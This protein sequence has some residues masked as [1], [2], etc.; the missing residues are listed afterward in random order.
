MTFR[1][2]DPKAEKSTHDLIKPR[3]VEIIVIN[4]GTRK[5]ETVKLE[6]VPQNP[7]IDLTLRHF[8]PEHSYFEL[9]IPPFMEFSEDKTYAF[10]LSKGNA[11][12]LLD[13]K[14]NLITVQGKT[15]DTM[16]SSDFQLFIFTDELCGTLLSTIR[17]EVKALPIIYRQMKAG[18]QNTIALTFPVDLANQVQVYSSDPRSLYLPQTNPDNL[19]TV[20]PG[21]INYI[22]VH[23]KTYDP[24]EKK[25]IVNAISKCPFEFLFCFNLFFFADNVSGELVYSWLIRM[26]SLHPKPNETKSVEAL[27][28]RYTTAKIMFC[29]PSKRELLYEFGTSHPKVY[30]PVDECM[31]F[32][33][34]HA[35]SIELEIYPQTQVCTFKTYLFINDVEHTV[36]HCIELQIRFLP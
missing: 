19:Q 22:E 3:V 25:V 5:D 26:Q 10:R 6:L 28:N 17:V 29:N 23:A 11:K 18:M 24:G 8:E 2:V 34:E 4:V 16:T 27:I 31:R 21:M 7:M 35:R 13:K 15:G 1:D 12:A 14:S 20:I 30:R 36:S 33:G 32:R 9:T